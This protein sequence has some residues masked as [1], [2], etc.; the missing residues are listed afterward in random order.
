MIARQ[1]LHSSNQS[2][3]ARQHA[4]QSRTVSAGCVLALLVCAATSCVL[5][6]SGP[7]LPAPSTTAIASYNG[8]TNCH[9]LANGRVSL[10]AVAPVARVLEF[11]LAGGT[12]L[13]W[14][15][16]DLLGQPAD[17]VVGSQVFGG[18][19][20]WVAPQCKWHPRSPWPPCPVLESGPCDVTVPGP[21]SLAMKG[22]EGS[23]HGVR[24]D[25]TIRL[26]AGAG[27]AELTYTMTDTSDKPVQ[28]G[29]WSVIQLRPGGRILVP[30]SAKD[31]AWFKELPGT[32]DWQRGDGLWELP[33][34]GETSKLFARGAAGW[35]AYLLDDVVFVLAFPPEPDATFPKGEAGLEVFTG[36]DLIELE[37]VSPLHALMPGQQVGMHESWLALQAPAGAAQMSAADLR[38]WIE[39]AI[40]PRRRLGFL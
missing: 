31:Q 3:F 23:R 9:V 16:H 29:I 30:V 35:L 12:N 20:L 26:P 17:I 39:R 34:R 6:P 36:E 19:K 38:T 37:H 28:W 13:F 14:Q 5:L 7:P 24:F 15:N 2:D 18:A 22:C 4:R 8:W 1:P 32:V 25:R 10:T 27:F 33:H 21:G 40:R 11:G